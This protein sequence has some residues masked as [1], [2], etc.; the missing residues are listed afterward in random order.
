[1]LAV[2]LLLDGL[3][4]GTTQ[5]LHQPLLMDSYPPA[6]RV[7]VFSLY[8]AFDSFGNVLAP[9]LV[10]LLAGVLGFTW[11]GV[12][13]VMAVVCFAVLPD[14]A[15]AA[16]PRLRPLGHRAA[17]GRGARDRRRAGRR[18]REPGLLRD[19]PAAAADPDGEE[20]AGRFAVFGMLLIPFQS[21]LCFYLDEE[22]NFGPGQRGLFFAL[23]SAA[24]IAR[25]PVRQARRGAVPQE[26]GPR[27][28]RGGL[29]LGAG[30]VL[31]CLAVVSRGPG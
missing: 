18:G 2:V 23:T 22:L 29:L 24:S 12:F 7:R 9:L 1:V 27:G 20:A 8:R 19:H 15:A 10:A 31:I 28:G 25:D 30:V 4:S 16:G 26:P 13:L 21:F 11:R 6:A 3:S 14:D 5:A 17:A